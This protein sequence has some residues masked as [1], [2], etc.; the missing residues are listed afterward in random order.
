[1]AD[2]DPFPEDWS[3]AL[4]V[5]A[6]PDDLEYG[7]ASAIARWTGQGKDI[8]YLLVTRGEAG[9]ASRPPAEV[10]PLREEEQRASAAVVGVDVV[11]FLDYPD[12]LVEPGLPLRRDL[13]RSVRV[14]RP[15]IVVSINFRESWGTG[16][17][18]HVDHRVVGEALID[19][20]RDAANPWVF[21]EL[22]AEGHEPWAGVRAVAFGG[23][24]QPT[25]AVDVTDTLERGVD[26][27]R[28]HATYLAGLGADPMADPGEFLR[29][30]AA[31]TGPRLGVAAAVAFEL[32]WS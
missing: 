25:H 20:V 13:A 31:A 15:D 16:S 30:N 28:A 12:G 11:E 21:T 29:A 17:W 19:A 23:S 9:I 26:S 27:L 22:R 32:I 7:V 8:R 3:R 14:H 24:T 2:L 6:H 4:A 18:N 10:G 5:V 1:M